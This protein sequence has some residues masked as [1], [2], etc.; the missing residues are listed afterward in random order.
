MDGWID[1]PG[2][3][4]LPPSARRGQKAHN[5]VIA[6]TKRKKKRIPFSLLSFSRL[7]RIAC[8]GVLSVLSEPA[9]T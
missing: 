7:S 6:L 8:V 9:A 1:G 5:V 4:A 3:I 2:A